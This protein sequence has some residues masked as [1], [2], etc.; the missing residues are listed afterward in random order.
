MIEDDHSLMGGVM[1]RSRGGFDLL[2][3]RQVSCS[4]LLLICNVKSLII[5]PLNVGY[6]YIYIQLFVFE[7]LYIPDTGTRGYNF[8]VCDL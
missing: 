1:I 6:L 4:R 3:D 2:V 7:R 5:V 8:V